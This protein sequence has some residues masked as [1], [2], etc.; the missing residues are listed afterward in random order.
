[1]KKKKAFKFHKNDLLH[2]EYETRLKA[3]K[4]LGYS[5]YH[6]YLLSD[7]WTKIRATHLKNLPNCFV[8]NKLATE[9][10]HASYDVKVLTGENLYSLHSICRDCHFAG[11]YIGNRKLSPSQATTR[12][13]M[14]KDL[15]EGKITVATRKEKE[16]LIN[17][18]Q[19]T[20]YKNSSKE[21]VD[22]IERKW[23]E[24]VESRSNTKDYRSQQT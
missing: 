8:C 10:H 1:M 9:I 18:E 7:I 5:T 23:K 13:Y 17:L 20:K 6:E 2:R 24:F 11:E 14:L 21:K 4:T 3:L 15:T 16:R 22:M 12:M 19:K